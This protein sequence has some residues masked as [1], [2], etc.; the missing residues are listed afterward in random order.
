MKIY[1][2]PCYRLLS[3]ILTLVTSGCQ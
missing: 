3:G 2:N 1:R